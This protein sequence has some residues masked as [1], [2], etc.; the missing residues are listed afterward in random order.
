MILSSLL[1][2]VIKKH[3][4]RKTVISYLFYPVSLI[5]SAVQDKRRKRYL[6]TGKQ[7]RSRCKIISV[8]NIVSGGSGKTP[9][10]IFLANYLTKQGYKV[11]VSHRGYKGKFEE[12][13]R[14][15]S[16]RESIYDFAEEA[17]DEAYLLAK[18]LQGIPVI[19]G[20]KR[21]ENIQILEKKFPDLQIVI[22]DDSFQHL[23]VKH[24]LDI[25]V[26]N[27]NGGYGNGFVLPAGILRESLAAL[28]Y[29]DYIFYNGSGVIPTKI[30]Q[31]RKPILQGYY[32]IS[33]FYNSKGDTITRNFLKDK[34]ILLLSGIGY[35]ESFE[36]TIK[37]KGLNFV[38]HLVF[39]DHHEYEGNKLNTILKRYKN[40]ADIILTTEKDYAKLEKVKLK[41]PLVVTAIEFYL[42]EID[43]FSLD[44]LNL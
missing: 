41:L 12:K 13:G 9:I 30:L 33:R 1:Q 18:R 20:R 32:K 28:N 19:A 44:F 10:T 11:A 23:K 6:K 39:A 16:D 24:D 34:K 29:C 35:P 27:S 21:T 8:G 2:D 3:L 4:Y 17:G 43:R 22:L 5:Y 14:L 26:F 37:E 25:V 40:K 36:H 7:F 15:I 42:P 38:D 31:S